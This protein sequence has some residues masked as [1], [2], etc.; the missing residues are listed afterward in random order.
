MNKEVFDL[1]GEEYSG[2]RAKH[3]V[4]QI[5]NFHR[6]Q[7]SPGYRAAA[8]HVAQ[9]LSDIGLEVEILKYPANENASF[10]NYSSFQETFVDEAKLFLVTKSLKE[11]IADY[12]ENKL[13]VIQRSMSTQPEGIET[14]LVVLDKGETEEEYKNV[15][16]KGK[17]V[18]VSGDL[19][20]VL[21]LAVGK[22]GAIGIISDRLPELLPVRRRLDLPNALQYT[23]FWW[24][25][26]MKKCFGFVI[27][28]RRGAQI[29]DLAK[30]E[31]LK[32]EATVKS[33]IYDGTI[34]VITAKIPGEGE[35]EILL[36]AHLCH[37]Q[38][39]ANDNA[40]GVGAL[41]EAARTLKTLIGGGKLSK[42]KKTIR[43][44]FIPEMT[45]TF[46]YIASNVKNLRNIVAGVNL[47]MVGE[48]QKLCGSILMVERTPLSLPTFINAYV[49]YLFNY[50]TKDVKTLSESE[51]LSSFNYAFISFSGGSDHEILSDPSVGVPTISF[52]NWPDRY[53][54]TSEDTV[55]KV[56]SETLWNVGTIATT[57]AYTLAC[58]DR[59]DF[60]FLALLTER[61]CENIILKLFDE[62]ILEISNTNS[63]NFESKASEQLRRWEDQTNLWLNYLGSAIEGLEK[64]DT[65]N[66]EIAQIKSY[67]HGKFKGFL[68]LK[69][70]KLYDQILREGSKYN[71]Y[72]V[73]PKEY[74]EIKLQKQASKYV[75][76]RTNPGPIDLKS[77]MIKLNETEQKKVLEL[78]R[79]NLWRRIAYISLC[80]ADGKRNLWDVARLTEIETG[81]SKHKEVIQWFKLLEKMGFINLKR[82]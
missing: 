44:L 27:S 49:E 31:I 59:N 69:R 46:A 11:K 64:F 75:P 14:E 18:L 66:Q 37:P 19:N 3:I 80:W 55:D 41:I 61:F 78:Q 21:P 82:V 2:E 48:D 16:V 30:R 63:R 12:Q 20:Y 65:A 8:N 24:H 54:H 5:I 50:L 79:K 42:P 72:K 9:Q 10:W 67:Y 32:V 58:V 39:S 15:D 76:I 52:T 77:K 71:V 4:E 70:T 25:T 35:K 53:Y 17:V 33:K 7:A 81:Y 57:F 26:G 40:S 74:G 22:Y 6:I 45:G 68:E 56:C 23:S 34:E 38:P 36:T 13:S 60:S 1:I 73:T 29:R 28:P 47:D 43:F 62:I 51:R